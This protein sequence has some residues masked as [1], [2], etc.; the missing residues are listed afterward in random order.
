MN[1]SHRMGDC[2]EGDS[3]RMRALSSDPRKRAAQRVDGL[4]LGLLMRGRQ[5]GTVRVRA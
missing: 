3:E 5:C 4:P 1:A 2:G